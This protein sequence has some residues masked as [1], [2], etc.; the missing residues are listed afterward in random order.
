MGHVRG[1]EV[2]RLQMSHYQKRSAEAIL[3]I[4][5]N[6][7]DSHIPNVAN[8]TATTGP[9]S[10]APLSGYSYPDQ[11]S[12]PLLYLAM[13]LSLPC[14]DILFNSASLSYALISSSTI[15]CLS[16]NERTAVT[17]TSANR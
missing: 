2:N 15:Y 17:S 6:L 12:R 11:V 3:Q 7:D 5:S 13:H 1:L 9:F 4:F 10:K 16:N 8:F 14:D